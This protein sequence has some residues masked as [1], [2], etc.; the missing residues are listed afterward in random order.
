MEV[1]YGRNITFPEGRKIV[2]CNMKDKNYT[3][4][5]QKARSINNTADINIRVLIKKIQTS[6][7]WNKRF[8]K[9]PRTVKEH[10]PEICETET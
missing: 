5:A 3:N 9:I 8:I 4:E 10:S 1:K 7:T 6:A 2:E